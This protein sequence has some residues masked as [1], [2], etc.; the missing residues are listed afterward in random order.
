MPRAALQ[1]SGAFLHPGRARSRGVAAECGVPARA[2]S[3][4]STDKSTGSPQATVS[5]RRSPG[6]SP[7]KVRQQE[8]LQKGKRMLER[9]RNRKRSML[10]SSSSS[11]SASSKQA[12]PMAP[13][14]EA[15]KE[16]Q[17]NAG[18]FRFGAAQMKPAG[19]QAAGP[20]D[21]RRELAMPQVRPTD[22]CCACGDLSACAAAGS[23]SCATCSKHAAERLRGPCT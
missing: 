19:K 17:G 22:W 5:L 4:M 6:R 10:A 14:Q 18:P 13:S 8:M 23:L 1:T 15:D 3:S 2:R 21:A 9:Y 11:L 12:S 16:N 7:L 20:Q